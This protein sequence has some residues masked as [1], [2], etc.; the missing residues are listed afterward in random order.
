MINHFRSLRVLNT[1]SN[2]WSALVNQS[3][4][5]FNYQDPF[6]LESQLTGDEKTIKDV[7]SNF[8]KN[9]LLPNVVSSFRHEKFDINIMKEMGNLGLLGSTINGY[10]CAG[11]NYVSY[12]LIMREIERVDSGYRSC[13]SVQSSLV[14]FPIYKFGSQEQKDKYL[15]ELAKGNLIGCFGLT[16]P[17]H[18]S[19]P[20]GMK[21]KATF[22][23]GKYILNGSKNWITNSPIADVFI[24]WAKDENNDIRGFILEKDM[25]GLSCPRIEGKFS[26]RSSYTGMIFMDNVIVPKENMLPHVKGLKGPF[27]CLNNA[28]YGISWGVLGAAEDCYLRAREYCSDRKQFNR[29]LAA[30]QII[31]LKL[32]DMLTEITLGT[33]ASL[34]IGRLLDENIMIPENISII[35]RNNCIKALTVARN[36]RDMLGGNGISDEYHVIRHMLNLEAVNTYEGT[37]DIHALIVGKG[38]TQI[39]SFT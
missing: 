3:R 11:V 22:K 17:D 25:N 23:D 34:R 18:G 19:D 8:S 26:L 15:P 39:S 16:E 28:R 27:S 7:A 4:S 33:Q 14:M 20:S 31:Q 12:G 9:Y 38:I 2:A 32:T 1:R 21:T 37:Q 24:I 35:K 30:N 5:V 10:G 6:L 13:A 36:A 29:P